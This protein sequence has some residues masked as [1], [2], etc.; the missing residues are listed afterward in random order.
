MPVYPAASWRP[1]PETHTQGRI[2]PRAVIVHST[3][4]RGSLYGWWLNPDSDGLESHFWVSLAGVV[5]Q[6]VDT[7]VRAD[8]NG[9]ANGFAVSI[10]TE[11]SPAATE[12][13]TDAQA[14]AI[15]DLIVWCCRTHGIPPRVMTSSTGSGLGWHVMFGAPGPWTKVR[16]KT[17]PGPARI[18]QFRGEVVPAVQRALGAQPQEDP[19]PM[20]T[21]AEQREL[22]TLARRIDKATA[23]IQSGMTMLAR[24]AGLAKT[25]ARRGWARI[26]AEHEI[27]LDAEE[28]RAVSDRAGQ[29]DDDARR[30]EDI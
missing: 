4:G 24:Q 26:R 10:E 2:R 14:R 25:Y 21:D 17:C 22:L 13:W 7:A 11:S 16:G 15:V 9:A 5:E 8:A 12:R 29:I 6:Y 18:P 3:A 1:I 30:A 23:A 20:L 28:R 27:T 19:F